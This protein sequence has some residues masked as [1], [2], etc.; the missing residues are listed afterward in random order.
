MTASHI[1]SDDR[2]GDASSN[3]QLFDLLARN[4]WIPASQ[5]PTMYRMVGFRNVLVHEY[6]DVDVKLVRLVLERHTGDLQAFV[7]AVRSRL[8]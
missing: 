6:E 5:V 3:H 7:D 4:G 1:V 8:S 2:L